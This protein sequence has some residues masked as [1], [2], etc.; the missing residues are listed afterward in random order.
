MLNVSKGGGSDGSWDCF[1]RVIC[2]FDKIKNKYHFIIY[3]QI[4][5][6]SKCYQKFLWSDLLLQMKISIS[7]D[8]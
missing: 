6:N 2:M 8:I 3:F 1:Y 7:I 4:D 5:Y